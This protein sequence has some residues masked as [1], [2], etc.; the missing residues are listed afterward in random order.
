MADTPLTL[1]ETASVFAEMLTFQRLLADAPDKS[2][3]AFHAGGKN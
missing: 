2:D 3:K 1:A